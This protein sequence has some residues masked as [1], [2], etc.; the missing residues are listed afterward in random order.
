MRIVHVAEDFSSTNTG[1]TSSVRELALASIAAGHEVALVAPGDVGNIGVDNLPIQT[2][3]CD[4]I[5]VPWRYSPKFSEKLTAAVGKGAIVHIHGLWMF[6]QWQAMRLARERG[7]PVVLTLHNMLGGWLWRRG[8]GRRLKK[9]LYFELMVKMQITA[10]G[11]VHGLSALECAELRTNFFPMSRIV[12]IPNAVDLASIDFELGHDSTVS[13]GHDRYI[14]F[15]GRLHPVKGI[16]LL[17]EAFSSSSSTNQV[18]LIIAGPCSVPHYE[19][20]LKSKARSLGLE[21]SVV[22]C[23][24]VYGAEKWRL[25]AGAWA[26]CAP[27]YSEGISMAALEAMAASVPVITTKGAGLGDVGAAGGMLVGSD[28]AEIANALAKTF[29]WN[30]EE[31]LARGSMARKNIEA[32]YSWSAVWPMY[33]ALYESVL[34]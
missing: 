27:S 15:F 20:A 17:L 24:P 33:E 10:V 12:Q 3:P 25:L 7:W 14:L 31:R 11:A 34:N 1:I 32:N 5:G 19:E 23:G 9:R 26:L 8:L 6:P 21:Q 13:S 30:Y 29:G 16:E 4:G 2:T 28:S 18:R 22:F